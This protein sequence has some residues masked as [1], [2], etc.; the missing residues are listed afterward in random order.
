MKDQVKNLCGMGQN[1]KSKGIRAN[2]PSLY[3]A[4]WPGNH[5]YRLFSIIVMSCCVTSHIF[6]LLNFINLPSAFI[7]S[8]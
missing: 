8:L 4:L 5:K 2:W 3:H 1:I 7:Q 6:I